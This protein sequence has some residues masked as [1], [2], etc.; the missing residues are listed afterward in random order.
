MGG[1]AC[2]RW[3]TKKYHR[4]AARAVSAAYAARG[5]GTHRVLPGHQRPAK[6]RGL[7]AERQGLR[8]VRARI[9]AVVV[10]GAGHGLS[11]PRG[12]QQLTHAIH[13]PPAAPG[14]HGWEPAAGAGRRR[15]TGR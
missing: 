13:E 10:R 1:L 7:P 11:G 15:G 12:G 6:L 9:V 8:Q 14:R 5:A 2:V 4:G 3:C